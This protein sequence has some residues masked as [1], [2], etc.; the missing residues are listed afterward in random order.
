MSPTGQLFIEVLQDFVRVGGDGS[1]IAILRAGIDIN[2]R[3][4]VVMVY[5][6]SPNRGRDLHQISHQL[7][8]LLRDH[9]NIH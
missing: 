5:R 4:H 7:W 3:L 9:R 1:Q 6:G 8:T 2:N